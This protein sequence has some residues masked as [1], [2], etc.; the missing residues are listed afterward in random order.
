MALLSWT[1]ELRTGIEIVDSQH[2]ELIAK[3]NA[4][5]E[6]MKVGKGKEKIAEVFNF[7]ANYTVTHFTTE[8]KLMTTHGY[9]DYAHHKSEHTALIKKVQEMGKKLQ[10][11]QI[12]LTIETSNFLSDWVKTHILK[13]DK[14]YIP[15]FKT[16]NIVK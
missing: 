6:A 16:K 10:E 4:L 8:E 15:F 7:L 3:V 13:E 12:S 11:G 5:H 14:A 9:P 1:E 2:K